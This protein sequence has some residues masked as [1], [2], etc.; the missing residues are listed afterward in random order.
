MNRKSSAGSKHYTKGVFN[1]TLFYL[2]ST[3]F[4]S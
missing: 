3:L 4:F 2:A 1:W